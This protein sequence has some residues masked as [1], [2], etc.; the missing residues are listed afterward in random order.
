MKLK[1]REALASMSQGLE[2][3]PM[4]AHM[5]WPRLKG[6]QYGVDRCKYCGRLDGPDVDI[7]WEHPG[8]IV[9]KWNAVPA[10][11]EN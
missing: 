8:Q 6:S 1:K 9:G 3:N 11:S 4:Q 7:L 2:A 5:I 10:T